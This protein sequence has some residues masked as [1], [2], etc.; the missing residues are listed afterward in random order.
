MNRHFRRFAGRLMFSVLAGAL[1][2]LVAWAG[3]TL[4]ANFLLRRGIDGVSPNASTPALAASANKVVGDWPHYIR[5]WDMRYPSTDQ[6]RIYSLW[7]YGDVALGGGVQYTASGTQLCFSRATGANTC[8]DQPVYAA[9]CSGLNINA[10]IANGQAYDM[11]YNPISSP[12]SF[13]N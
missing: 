11:Q 1:S 2:L 4:A 9:G 12:L 8:A 13:P 5:C 7:Y 3:I 6:Q 10:I